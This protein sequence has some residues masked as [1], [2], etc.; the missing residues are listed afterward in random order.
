MWRANLRSGAL[1]APTRRFRNPSRAT[2]DARLRQ[3]ASRYQFTVVEV[4]IL[5]PRQQAPFVVV[6]TEDKHALAA[7]TAAIL[8]LIDPKARTDDDRTGWAYEGF[9]FGARDSHGVPFLAT[10][11]W[12]RGAHTDGGQWAADPSLYPSN[13]G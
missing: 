3:A 7:S 5:H 13:H 4:Q 10:F 1:S 8:H 12:W 6:E 11:N 9:L 2:L